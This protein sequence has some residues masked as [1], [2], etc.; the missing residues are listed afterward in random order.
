MLNDSTKTSTGNLPFRPATGSTIPQVNVAV[1]AGGDD[2]AQKVVV[3]PPVPVGP[4]SAV[5]TQPVSRP[6]EF[7]P[8]STK[9]VEAEG[10]G[11]VV[12]ILTQVE[13]EKK[14]E[15]DGFVA[16]VKKEETPITPVIDDYTNEILLNQ[17]SKGS[18]VITLPLT[19]QQVEEDLHKN[20]WESVRWLAEWCVRQVKM[21][22]G[23]VMYRK[24]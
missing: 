11:E 4:P 7:E 12:E 10:V 24:Q 8:V 22:P 6:K 21:L 13:V 19:Q 15:L 20:I 9:A 3:E 17:T 1:K 5:P 16:A 23:R 2:V 14:P 18:S